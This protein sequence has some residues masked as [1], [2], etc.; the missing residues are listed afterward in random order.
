VTRGFGDLEAVVMDRL[1]DRDG[2]TTVRMVFEDMLR[3]REIAYTTVMSTMDNLHHKGWLSRETRRKSLSI[4]AEHDPRT[5]RRRAHARGARRRRPVG[6]RARAFPG[7]DQRR[8]L[9]GAA[10]SVAAR[11]VQAREVG[12][13]CAVSIAV[14]LLLY[15]AV[16]CVVAPRL[17]PP[18]DSPR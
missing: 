1:W 6:S 7:S 3:D 14:C 10:Q 12:E 13:G 9:R 16:V 11:W 8:R 2:A 5:V 15:A 4:L 18:S 17:L